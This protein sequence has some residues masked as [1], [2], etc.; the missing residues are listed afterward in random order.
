[1]DVFRY[2]MAGDYMKENDLI[3]KSID[4]GARIEKLHSYLVKTTHEAVLS[5]QIL[6][7]GT[8]IGVNIIEAQYGSSKADFFCQHGRGKHEIIGILFNLS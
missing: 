3:D 4:F 6:R 1:M 5:M 2:N 7:S 8:S